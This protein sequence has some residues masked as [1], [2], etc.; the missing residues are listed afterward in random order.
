M[1]LTAHRGAA[2]V[3]GSPEQNTPADFASAVLYDGCG[4][5]IMMKKQIANLMIGASL[6]L[7]PTTLT[8][9]CAVAR[10]Q[11]TARE[12][13][14]DAKITA[15]VKAKLYKDAD[16]KGTQVDV[17]TMKGVVQL[18]GF[19]DSQ[20]AKDRAG[21]IASSIPGVVDVHNDLIL[22]TGRESAQ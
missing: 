14:E 2:L 7:L 19:V 16:V 22:P 12:Y 5:L 11:E 10:H 15:Q 9:G 6:V 20:T 4:D 13:G 8:T 21:Q 1:G 18:S 17:T 3:I